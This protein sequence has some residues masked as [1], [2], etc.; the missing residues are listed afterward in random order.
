[1]KDD[2]YARWQF[3]RDYA[4]CMRAVFDVWEQ[5]FCKNISIDWLSHDQLRDMLMRLQV[6]LDVLEGLH[7]FDTLS[8]LSIASENSGF[9]HRKHLEQ[10]I[11][12]F[13]GSNGDDYSEK[14]RLIKKNFLETLFSTSEINVS[15][16]ERVSKAQS[17]EVLVN[18]EIFLPFVFNSIEEL[19]VLGKG[20][21][22]A[23]LC[24]WERYVVQSLPVKYVMLFEVSD[25]WAGDHDDLRQL[26][27]IL[28][29]ETSLIVKMNELARHID[30]SHALI[31]PK[32]IGRVILG[33]VFISHLTDDTHQLQNALNCCAGDGEMLN[34]SRIIYEYVIAEEEHPTTSLTDSFGRFHNC[35]QKYAVRKL[36]P[37]HADRGVTHV[38]KHLFAPHSVIQHL[39]K[40]FIQEIGH[41]L[42]SY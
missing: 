36:E 2:V 15:H 19:T 23:F 3:M 33:P 31:H 29:E 12:E 1:M 35:I 42:N 9:P 24:T 38:E 6:T 30:M 32:W 5:F 40:E 22:R 10:L 13:N 8:S 16:L 20:Q 21:R 17:L 28:R 14:T 41:R 34:A 25:K 18:R 7:L 37:E 26:I 27:H 39:D 11:Y 4:R